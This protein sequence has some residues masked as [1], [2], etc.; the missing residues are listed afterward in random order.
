MRL[1]VETYREMIKYFKAIYSP[2]WHPKVNDMDYF[3]GTCQD[4]IPEELALNMCHI[5]CTRHGQGPASV[6]DILSAFFEAKKE[7]CEDYLQYL[8]RS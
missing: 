8:I 1:T 6:E 5:Y 7:D 4:R 3:F 2:D